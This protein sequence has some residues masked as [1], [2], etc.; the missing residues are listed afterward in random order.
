LLENPILKTILSIIFPVFVVLGS[1]DAA[2]L[3]TKAPNS[4]YADLWTN[5]PFTSKPPP[6]PPGEVISPFEDY[7]LLGVSPVGNGYR[8][9]LMNR[10]DPEARILVETSRP[11]AEHGFKITAVNRKPGDPLGTSVVLNKGGNSG[12]VV[13]DSALLTLKAPPAPAP[14]QNPAAGIPGLPNQPGGQPPGQRVPRPRV[15]PPPA[16]AAAPGAN[17]A[18]GQPPQAGGQRPANNPVRERTNRRR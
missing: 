1:M 7:A 18:A 3:P 16:P 12:T 6:P 9:T 14:P 17:P 15:V 5:S 4:K 10:K 13:F 11:D 2:D 8:V